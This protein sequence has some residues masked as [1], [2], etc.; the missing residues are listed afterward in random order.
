M[1]KSILP[2]K[3]DVPS[4]SSI[5]FKVGDRLYSALSV[6]GCDV[7]KS[8]YREQIEIALLNGRSY[9]GIVE[10]LPTHNPAGELLKHPSKDSIAGHYKSGHSG[11]SAAVQRAVIE[12]RHEDMGLD[13]ESEVGQAADKVLLAQ[14]IVQ[15]GFERLQAGEIEPELADILRAAALLHQFEQAS[16]GNIDEQVWRDVMLVH[17]TLAQQ[18]IP[19][20]LREEYGRAIEQHP[21]LKALRSQVNEDELSLEPLA[22]EAE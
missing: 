8:P 20:H 17:L 16:G 7:C 4:R 2:D 10:D 11:I 1:G 6:A 18:F 13:L 12:R 9:R 22:I 19:L 21:I 15:R 5:S 14:L 3:H